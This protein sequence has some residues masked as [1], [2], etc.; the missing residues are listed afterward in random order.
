[1]AAQ[2]VKRRPIIA[3][4][5]SRVRDWDQ[6][7]LKFRE[8]HITK[9]I[10]FTGNAATDR[11]GKVHSILSSH[12]QAPDL[13]PLDEEALAGC[14]I[15]LIRSTVDKLLSG[16]QPPIV[17]VDL[18]FD[19]K[20]NRIGWFDPMVWYRI[21]I[22]AYKVDGE[23]ALCIDWKTG[24]VRDDFAQLRDY[25]VAI[26]TCHP[27]VNRVQTAYLWVDGDHRP[28]GQTYTRAQFP[29]LRAEIEANMA[30]IEEGV[31]TKEFPKKPGI[32]CKWCAIS[33]KLCE[34]KL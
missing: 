24:K 11:G 32:L 2:P 17:E 9:S 21:K 8:S 18:A 4:S 5:P 15:K 16:G 19:R 26:F 22:D 30:R 33:P 25:A 12:L 10:K 1:M 6:C 13:S 20:W 31:R 34:H 29:G 28:T 14:N 3:G 7:P 23:E 27:G